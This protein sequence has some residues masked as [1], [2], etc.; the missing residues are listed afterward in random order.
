VVT[1]L[2][3]L[4]RKVKAGTVLGPTIYTVGELIDGDPPVWQEGTTV[5]TTPEQARRAVDEQKRAGYDAVKVYDNLLP[6]RRSPWSR[7]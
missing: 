5:V 1:H 3:E 6:P 2:L 4:R 7:W